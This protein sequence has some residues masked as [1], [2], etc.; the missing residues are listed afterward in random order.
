MLPAT[1]QNTAYGLVVPW[2]VELSARN[3]SNWNTHDIDL[4]LAPLYSIAFE[5]ILRPFF[6]LSGTPMPTLRQARKCFRSKFTAQKISCTTAA[7]LPVE[8]E[9]S[10]PEESGEVMPMFHPS[11]MNKSMMQLGTYTFVNLNTA[12]LRLQSG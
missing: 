9:L 12:S 7:L 3:C 4:S 1:V 8:L 10:S 6:A 5:L 2:S 11:I